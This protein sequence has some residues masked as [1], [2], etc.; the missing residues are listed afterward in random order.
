T[1]CRLTSRG[2]VGASKGEDRVRHA[3]ANP[4]SLNTLVDHPRRWE[5]RG[6]SNG[7]R[8]KPGGVSV[9]R[10]KEM[11]KIRV[12]RAAEGQRNEP[13]RKRHEQK[14]DAR[15]PFRPRMIDRCTQLA[16]IG[17]ADPLQLR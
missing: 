11:L 7:S 8:R 12:V 15:R 9:K 10:K 17:E 2:A 4:Q 13:C 16:L 1:F 3:E 14:H 5:L 6:L